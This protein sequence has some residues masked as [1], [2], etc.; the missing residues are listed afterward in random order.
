VADATAPA[1][2]L[3]VL[4]VITS[5]TV[6]GAERL[7]VS[8][9]ARLPRGRFDS[10]IC[11]FAARGPL[12]ADAEAAGVPIWCLDEFPGVGHPLA[13]VRLLRLIRGFRPDIVHTHLQ[14]PNLYGRLA[15]VLAGVPRIAATEHNV[16]GAKAAR[17]VGVERALAKRTHA[18]IAVSNEVRGFLAAQLKIA[19]SAIRV[20]R[21]G[22]APATV[23]A[24]RA[25]DFRRMAG[26]GAGT[27]IG[28]VASLTRK[29]GHDV[30]LEALARLPDRDDVHVLVA[31]DGPE[32]AAL[33]Q[34]A[35]SLGLGGRVHFLGNVANPADVL[36]ASDLFVLPSRI[37]GLPLALLEAMQAGKA[38]VATAVGG[39]A[40]AV[41]DGRSGLLVPPESPDALATAIGRLLVSPPLREQLGAAA[42][43]TV[44]R[45]F[46]EEAYLEALAALYEELAGR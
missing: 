17:Y 26:G 15:A 35:R 12:A 34:L 30:L 2:R 19:P 42:R 16:Y 24:D 33:E 44:S 27:R 1:S 41:A 43:E 45:G 31:G 13:F 18:L 7:V 22:V 21:N 6:G 37:E 10:A 11:C 36:A 14:S 28:V 29:K 40:E 39:V 46:T 38:V 32:R 4:H 8:A 9:A 3:R 5:L 23:S 20:I 25:A